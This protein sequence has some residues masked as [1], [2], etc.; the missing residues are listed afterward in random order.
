M[1]TRSCCQ[2][3]YCV[4]GEDGPGTPTTMCQRP[5]GP[6][7]LKECVEPY[8]CSTTRHLPGICL[9]YEEAFQAHA[10]RV[11]KC[12]FEEII[13][14]SSQSNHRMRS[15]TC[16]HFRPYFVV[17][18]LKTRAKIA[19]R[20]VRTASSILISA[21]QVSY[22]PKH[23]MEDIE[24]QRRTALAADPLTRTISSVLITSFLDN[25]RRCVCFSCPTNPSS[26]KQA[27]L[28]RRRWHNRYQ[29][30]MILEKF[31]VKTQGH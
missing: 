16:K 11:R 3:K 31:N 24:I 10:I 8:F 1:T 18:W 2:R 23:R 26:S 12:C 19:F 13:V 4:H 21:R 17:L 22:L 20:L 7:Y 6:R 28:P 30:P 5:E 29:G 9:V 25:R 15:H 27:Y 14:C